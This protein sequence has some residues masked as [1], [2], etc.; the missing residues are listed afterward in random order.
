MPISTQGDS[1]IELS[2]VTTLYYSAPYLEEFCK[3]IRN[4]AE[5]ITTQYEIVLVN[6]GSPDDSLQVALTLYESDL[7]ICI[8][9][10]SRN[11]GHHRAMMTGLQN[12]KGNFVFL[13]DVDLEEP[14]ELLKPFWDKMAQDDNVD[15]V[16]GLSEEKEQPFI[17]KCFSDGFY[18]IFNRLTPFKMSGRDLVAR[19]MTRRYVDALLTY[20]ERELFIPAVWND[21]GFKQLPVATCKHFKGRSTYTLRKR[22]IMAV[23]AITSFSSKPLLFVF[24]AGAMISAASLTFILYLVI[25][26]LFFAEVILGWT[27]VMAS[28]YLMGGFIMFSLGVLGI[29]LSKVYTEIKGRP[30]SIIRNIY[31]AD[32]T[33]DVICSLNS[34]TH[35]GSKP[36]RAQAVGYRESIQ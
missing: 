6:D 7:R 12:A 16:Y 15:V 28:I 5:K 35:S 24:Y 33:D 31:A 34:R 13:I 21:V 26:K 27:S 9:D 1:E 18:F 17:R 29:Y 25:R 4:E 10:L 11:F 14:P 19:L 22:I 23:D 30:F 36:M 20:T 8:V 2:I 32:R 3:R